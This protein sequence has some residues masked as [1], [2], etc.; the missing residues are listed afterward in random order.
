MCVIIN[1]RTL[2][3]VITSYM[4]LGHASEC[5]QFLH[6]KKNIHQSTTA[7]NIA[8][9]KR[10]LFS[11]ESMT[12]GMLS[13]TPLDANGNKHTMVDQVVD[14]TLPPEYL[15]FAEFLNGEGKRSN[16]ASTI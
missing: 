13:M 1:P 16:V 7:Q 3:I 11:M 15:L 10:Y 14:L 6:G 9:E 5:M 2:L 4:I 12:M 8:T